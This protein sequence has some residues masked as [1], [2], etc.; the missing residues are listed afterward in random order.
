MASVLEARLVMKVSE[1]QP[2]QPVILCGDGVVRFK[3]NAIV[4]YLLDKATKHK[5]TDLN[6]IASLSFS[7]EDRIQFAQ[8]IGYSLSGFSDLSYVDDET[9]DTVDALREDL[10]AKIQGNNPAES[11]IPAPSSEPTP[12]QKRT[13]SALEEANRAFE[14]SEYG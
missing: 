2:T 14:E 13:S 4:R 10:M 8:L 1:K 3:E 5:T 7:N 12:E 9:W 6:E 11:S